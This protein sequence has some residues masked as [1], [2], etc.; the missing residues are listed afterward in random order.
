MEDITPADSVVP[1]YL[2]PTT[3]EELAEREQWAIN[4]AERQA[5]EIA[6]AAAKITA[7]AKLAKLGLTEEEITA[8]IG[9]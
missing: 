4:A 2:V 3:E 9:A 8:L 7:S 5:T 6:K 1:I